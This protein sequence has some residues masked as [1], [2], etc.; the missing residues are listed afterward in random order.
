MSGFVLGEFCNQK[1]IQCTD[2]LTKVSSYKQ[3]PLK[4]ESALFLF[5]DFHYLFTHS[6]LNAYIPMT[7]IIHLLTTKVV[8][9]PQSLILNGN[10]FA[11]WIHSTQKFYKLLSMFS[12][13][14][15]IEELNQL[16]TVYLKLTACFCM[17]ANVNTGVGNG[18]PLH[19]SCL[20]NPRDGK[21]DG[22]LSMGSHRVGHN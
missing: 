18:D 13:M 15:I 7:C 10:Y 21:P 12:I 22:L 11:F 3:T 2:V 8:Q 19:C 5:N 1:R 17:S 4:Y 20:E 6:L 9:N 16:N 14:L